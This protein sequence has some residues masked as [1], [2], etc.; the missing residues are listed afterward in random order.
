MLR[1]VH[2]DH[3]EHLLASLIEALPP[4][5]PFSPTTIVVGSH[6]V[7]RWLVRELAL[8]R[9]V[10]AGLELVT[11]DRFL[12]MTWTRGAPG[13]ASID[14]AQLASAIAS[15]LADAD[16]VRRIPAVESYLAAAPGAGDRAGPR[17]VQLA[18]RVAAL[19]WT[20]AGT[21]PDWMHAILEGR[22]PAELQDD[23]AAA[24]QV[25]LIHRALG[26]LG[27]SSADRVL[28]PAPVLPWARRRRGLSLPPLRPVFV[29]GFSYLLRSQLDALT[30]LAATTDVTVFVTDPC[31]ELWDDV[32]GRGSAA[33][34]ETVTDPLPLVMWGKP[35]RDTLAA[36]VERSGGDVEHRFSPIESTSALGRLLSDVR[37]RRVAGAAADAAPPSDTGVTVLSCPNSR[38]ELE[39]IAAQARRCLD[40]DPT[41]AANDIAVWIAGDAD[42]YL[43][44]GPAAFEAVGVPCHLIDAPIDDRGRVSE[45]ILA[46]L[47]LPTSN[48]TRRDL[49]RVMTHPAVLASHPSVDV[50]DWVRW[51]D[52]L[53]IAH[54]ADDAAHRHTYLED[55]PGHF[56][57]DQGVRRLAL[58]AFMVGDRGDRGL[59]RVAGRE[60]VPEEL[61]LDQ[62]ASG[63]TYALLV[64]SL[65][66]DARW[67]ARLEAPLA[68]WAEV[69]A[70]L[71]GAYLGARDREGERDLERVRKMLAALARRDLDRRPLGFREA[72]EHVRDL[73]AHA[74]TDRGE[75]LAF[76]VLISPLRAMRSL[77]FRRTFIAGLDEA[78]FP[79]SDEGSALDLRRVARTGDVSPRD[80]DRAAFLETILGTR[81]HLY[82]SYVGVE[83]NSGHVLSPSPIVLELADALAPYLGRASSR[84][85][86]AQLTRRVPL[87]RFGG[88]AAEAA[89]ERWAVG[90]RERL[91]AHLT[92]GGHAIPDEVGML[93]LLS[94]PA[95]VTL[96]AALGIVEAPPARTAVG[97]TR[98]LTIS[99]L[100]GFLEYP[101]Q[102]WA[103]SVLGLDELPDEEVVQRDDEPFV[104]DRLHRATLLR[105]VFTAHVRDATSSLEAIYDAATRDAQLRGQFPVGVFAEAAR[106]VDLRV[107][108]AWRAGLGPIAVDCATRIGFGRTTSPAARLYPALELPLRG[109]RTARLTGQT[110]LLLR[111]GSRFT[112]IILVNRDRVE[113]RS[114]Y[115]LRGAL[116]HVVLAAAGLALDGHAHRLIDANGA[117]TEIAHGAWS[118]DDARAYLSALI[119]DLVDNPH[120]YILP[121]ETL[122]RGLAGTTKLSGRSDDDHALG[123]G[124][125][126]RADGLALPADVPALSRRRLLPLVERMLGTEHGIEVS[127]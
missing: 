73:F 84:E 87:H 72:R 103:Q 58:G 112:S 6:V 88:P 117:T 34:A 100:R 3:V 35:V 57:W 4:V 17:R 126:D 52:R 21:R 29:F 69:F 28:V 98:S 119:E 116:D 115:H 5:D 63:A 42:D 9:G 46:I 106:I 14:R 113:K 16:A 99:N 51:T 13:L 45:A 1:A 7:E 43:A 82:L 67:L 91:R 22:V 97:T 95:Q 20:Y 11:F 30:D 32:S 124:P 50:T 26:P 33:D 19:C 110:E 93:T 81:D 92:A 70:D 55:H 64:R 90:V 76:G 105:D 2:S 48:M 75:P 79:A 10:A 38:R 66:E 44:Q 102:A 24:W 101:V 41:L 8:A 47:E 109:E 36:L 54:G 96:R 86:L 25:A 18:H 114:P 74:R 40:A 27:A 77:P 15:V 60:V 37:V 56:H 39:E 107:L 118:Q 71:V 89:R 65:C 31:E 85:A 111:D 59:A 62:Q 83:P 125:I 123:F 23:P 68:R 12:E 104:V 94:D 53:G 80:R 108:H 121:F 61:R 78:R 122:A 127:Q 49:L 120:G